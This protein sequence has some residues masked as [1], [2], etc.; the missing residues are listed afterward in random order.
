MMDSAANRLQTA[1]LRYAIPLLWGPLPNPPKGPLLTGALAVA[2]DFGDEAMIVTAGHVLKSLADASVLRETHCF[3]GPI[4]IR[5]TA[6]TATTN[7]MID[8]GTLR[9]GRDDI[10]RL[11][12]HH[13]IV[14][15]IVWPPPDVRPGDGVIIIG[16]PRDWRTIRSWN[17]LE[18]GLITIATPVT[19]VASDYIVCQM[20]WNAAHAFQIDTQHEKP[21]GE[22]SGSSGGPVFLTIEQRGIVVHHL[23][24]IVREEASFGDARLLYLSRL[25]RVRKDGTIA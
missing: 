22:F 9:I 20:E 16:A 19:Q 6:E 15:P 8:I 12:E 17:Q 18:A 2:V 13:R 4:E 25:D 10:A 24:A 23:C 5:W 14:R 21:V 1:L 7:M 11:E 3:L